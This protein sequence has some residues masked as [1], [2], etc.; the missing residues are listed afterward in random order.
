MSY[1]TQ[2]TGSSGIKETLGSNNTQCAVPTLA[3][4]IHYVQVALHHTF[5]SIT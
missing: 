2:G 4:D 3:L 5:A 1:L